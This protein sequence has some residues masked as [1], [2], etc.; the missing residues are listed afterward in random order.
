MHELRGTPAPGTPAAGA[1]FVRTASILALFL[2]I[3][4]GCRPAPPARVSETELVLGTAVTITVQGYEKASEA[5]SAAFERTRR[6]QDKMSANESNYDTTEVIAVNRNAGVGPVRVSDDTFFVLTEAL[7]FARLTEGR[8]DPTVYPLYKLWGMGTED[9]AVPS[10]EEIES[11]L[12]LVGFEALDVD[13]AERTVY[14]P[15]TGMG[16]DLGGIA[17][18]FAAVESARVLR[19]MGV[20]HALLD[21]GG[22]IVTIGTRP[23]GSRWRIG[24]QHP[25]G[26]RNEFLGILESTDES[27]VSSGAYERYFIEDGVRY[28]HIFDPDTGFPSA[29]GLVSVTVVGADA[30]TTDALSTAIF[31][32]GA[33]QGMELIESLADYDAIIATDDGRLYLTGNLAARFQQQAEEFELIVP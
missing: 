13:A 12:D 15:R 28:H 17:K 20:D 3:L 21:F 4:I 9:S 23:D 19:E 10:A 30:T 16:I 22:D 27:V 25:S 26:L 6:I 1:R 24:I 29:S 5:N 2:S 32:M 33:E 18:G 11:V 14:L 7:R 31:V 8:F